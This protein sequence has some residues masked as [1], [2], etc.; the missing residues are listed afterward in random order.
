VS[1]RR[2]EVE[3]GLSRF[4]LDRRITVFVL[5]V[6]CLVVGTVATL[7][8]PI[9]LI[10]AG[11]DEPFLSV[12]VPW[13]DAPPRESLD[14]IALPLEE[15]LNTVRGIGAVTTIAYT[16]GAVAY[17]RFKSG[18]DMDVAY[19]EVRDRVERARADF[20][21]DVDH[22][23]IRKDDASG[24]PALVLGVAVDPELADAYDLIQ[25]HIILPLS[26][27]DGVA[28]VETEGLVEKEI[29]IEIDRERAAAAG[30]NIYELSQDLGAD[31][32]TLASGTVRD[33]SRKL[34]L[35]SMARFETVEAL[36][37][38]IVASP[39]I[40]LR[41]V[42]EVRYAQ[43]E[44]DF[45]VRAM[46]K[47]A[48]AV[49]AL[50]EGQANVGDVS[51]RLTAAIER[52]QADPR[53]DGIEMIVLFGQGEVID[54]A[55]STL[56]ESGAVGGVIAVVVLF[57]F[58]RRLRLTLIL[59]LGIPLSLLIGLTV[60]FFAGETLNILTLLGLMLCV[61]LLVDNS[62][63]VAEN[64]HRLR[65]EGM[66]RREACIQG[67]GE[68][69]LAIT[70]STLTTIVVFLPAALIESQGQFFLLRLAIP[71]C[72]SVG[73]SLLVALVFIPLAVYVTLPADAAVPG[74]RTPWKRAYDGLTA[75][76]R[77]VYE[78]VFGSMNRAYARLL[79]VALGR[80]LE[81]VIALLAVFAVTIAVPMQKVELTDMQEEER[82]GFW[83]G[84]EMPPTT[85]L[86]ETE[87][88]FRRAEAVVEARKAE[89]GLEGWVLWHDKT[90]GE[91]QGWFTRPR[92][93]DLTPSEVTKAV[94]DAL[95]PKA[96]MKL[97][98]GDDRDT[99]ADAQRSEFTIV[100]Y[101]EDADVLEATGEAL[102][103]RL[104]R[105]E[106]VLG[107]KN[108]NQQTP[109]ELALVVDR[110]RAQALDV[111]PEV[112]AGVVAY[113]LRGSALPDYYQD[114]KEIPVRVRFRE[115][116][117]ESLTE[118]ADFGV[119]T[120][121]GAI[122]PVSALTDP[123][124]LSARSAIVRRDSR[125]GRVVSFDL[126]Q[127]TE[128][129]TRERLGAALAEFDFPEGVTSGEMPT[130]QDEDQKAMLFALALSIVFIYFLM[131]F[132]FESFV[133]PLSIVLTI[134]LAIVG[135]Y[136]I[137]FATGFELDF[138]GMVAAVLL[139]GVVVNNGIVLIDY[140]NRLRNQGHDRTDALLTAARLR[141]RPIMMTAITTI[142]GLIP[143]AFAGANSIGLSYTSFSL[144][145]IGGMSTATLLTLLVC[146]V[147]YTFFD[148][149]RDVLQA[150]L[151]AGL[152]RRGSAR[153]EVGEPAAG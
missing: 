74:R 12:R 141:F 21:D 70:M 89:L 112:V 5:F 110:E 13:E 120:N 60:M 94:K 92:S 2:Y 152:G 18:T 33:G 46:S 98:V 45:R 125:Q 32:F 150:S 57:L 134:P 62:V 17:M 59:A 76:L 47:P 85:S 104:V 102:E 109:E 148:D 114:G 14:K 37:N 53:L 87:E 97:T 77:W 71:V 19:R 72:V 67:A 115:E 153:P 8:I 26:R 139:V 34:L 40:R 50:K 146:P 149:A 116:D 88:W 11:Y 25:N 144:T 39:S 86:E 130:R 96:G 133:L 54:E 90:D 95:P 129:K 73:A 38:R 99:D 16:G 126:V 132:L 138:L 118:L 147:F 123:H 108:A 22:V 136:W 64:I 119:P 151:A 78:I 117:R 58:L 140:V 28:S 143:L 137:H 66:E 42:A 63:V 7:G 69:G 4:S 29:L 31:N 15:Q 35:R 103:D 36:E 131:G 1:A 127:G 6:S 61:G 83:I 84:V 135:V 111:N 122:L 23:Y 9:E 113:A 128:E 65:R 145:L 48:V 3:G 56:L 55:L 93:S 10:P 142:G 82:N 106:G 41:D 52:M 105:I 81:L 124:F 43:P 121:A 51:R 24:I 80:R 107:T 44:Q 75:G 100:L 68:V 79:A 101:G 49:M 20:P 91:V 27:V 30:L